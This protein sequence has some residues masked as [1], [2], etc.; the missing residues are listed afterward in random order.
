MSC[1]T[2]FIFLLV[3]YPRS[4]YPQ[5]DTLKSLEI[6]IR[7]NEYPYYVLPAGDNGLVVYRQQQ[8][9]VQGEYNNFEFFIYDHHLAPV[10]ESLVRMD[11][12]MNIIHHTYADDHIYVVF[13]GMKNFRKRLF[14]YRLNVVTH[15]QENIEITTFFPEVISYFALFGN[16]MVIG[17]RQKSKPSIVFYNLRDMRP[18]ILQGF[19]E[20]NIA[21]HDIRIDET[22]ELLTVTAGYMSNSRLMSLH[23]KSYDRSGE[24]VENIR[25]EPEKAVD[26]V[27][28]KSMIANGSYRLIAGFYKEKKSADASGIFTTSLQ[29]D[30]TRENRYYGFKDI[31]TRLDS[32]QQ[33][34][35]NSQPAYLHT[36]ML[37]PDKLE[38]QV[39]MLNEFRNDNIAILES[40]YTEKGSSSFM[41][42]SLI[43]HYQQALLVAVDDN[44]G[45]K[46]LSQFRLSPVVSDRLGKNLDVKFYADS[47][48]LT[49]FERHLLAKKMISSAYTGGPVHYTE[50]GDGHIRMLM[51]NHDNETILDFR[52]WYGDFFLLAGLLPVKDKDVDRKLVLNKIYFP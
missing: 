27:H 32:V 7:S 38:W 8:Q 4:V 5:M 35:M 44:L 20:K 13:S 28:A 10:R 45:L 14:I 46:G 25:I 29:L 23:I 1:K 34:G 30:G 6:T 39:T 37:S 50:M 21:I 52:S 47:V 48:R 17:G 24:P 36:P 16:T 15:A 12:M 43:Y 33:Q 18:V 11:Y 31:F 41:D 2:L 51:E 3:I 22:N 19:F 26:L 40:Y 42:K 49:L 9:D